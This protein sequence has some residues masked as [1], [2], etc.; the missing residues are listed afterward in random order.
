MSRFNPVIPSAAGLLAALFG[1]S[2]RIAGQS[3]VSPEAG[4]PFAIHAAEATLAAELAR[5]D[6][7][8]HDGTLDLQSTQDD[9]LI[10]GAT[11]CGPTT[12]NRDARHALQ[13]DERAQV[14]AAWNAVGVN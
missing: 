8:L 10:A 2:V 9:T 3:P 5:M 14:L 11:A 7:M 4:H 1:S 12:G 6:T 13:H